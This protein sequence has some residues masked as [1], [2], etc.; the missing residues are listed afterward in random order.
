MIFLRYKF[1]AV[2]V[3]VE[4]SYSTHNHKPR[5]LLFNGCISD[6]LRQ[7][8][9]TRECHCVL[10][11]IFISLVV[12]RLI[13]STRKSLGMRLHLHLPDSAL[14]LGRGFSASERMPHI[15]DSMTLSYLSRGE[16]CPAILAKCSTKHWQ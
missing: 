8:L 12:P 3:N 13:S 4:L 9:T 7:Q 5:T 6:F 11:S 10:M 15:P 2:E 14:L 16:E 1:L